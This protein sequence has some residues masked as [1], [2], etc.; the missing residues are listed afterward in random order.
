M[1][2]V[3]LKHVFGVVVLFVVVFGIAGVQLFGG[4]LH[5]RCFL[6]PDNS[7][8]NASL[9]NTS[10]R[11]NISA[12]L[13][14]HP[15]PEVSVTG[16]LCGPEF[17]CPMDLGRRTQ[18]LGS[19]SD[20]PRTLNG[21]RPANYLSGGV[22][23]FDNFASACLLIFQ[24]STLDSWGPTT[25]VFMR[26]S[27]EWQAVI[28]ILLIVF[29]GNF[30][31]LNIVQAVITKAYADASSAA[32]FEISDEEVERMIIALHSMSSWLS[33]G[34]FMTFSRSHVE[35]LIRQQR[36]HHG[37]THDGHDLETV[38]AH[39]AHKEDV[40]QAIVEGDS[41]AMATMSKKWTLHTRTSL[42]SAFHGLFHDSLLLVLYRTAGYFVLRG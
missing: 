10:A 24:L 18:C 31:L 25:F 17:A 12:L 21:D 11:A 35:Q 32:A 38:Q 6:V 13:V 4:D 39:E 27:G 2:V 28:F 40:H 34:N 20:W 5:S 22:S 41:A 42:Q 37:I 1:S 8:G 15:D 23:S 29:V 19:G 16:I 7:T 26:S 9:G 33:Q 36:Q 3:S 14:A 30:C